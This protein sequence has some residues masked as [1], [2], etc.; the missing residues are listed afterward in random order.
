MYS[1]ED[2]Q[3]NHP[4]P[5]VELLAYTFYLQQRQVDTVPLR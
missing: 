3:S 2:D 5:T 4:L 1:V